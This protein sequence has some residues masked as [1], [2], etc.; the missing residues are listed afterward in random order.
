MCLIIEFPQTQH[1]RIKKVKEISEK[2]RK[3]ITVD[4]PQTIQRAPTAQVTPIKLSLH[5]NG[6]PDL[7]KTL[8]TSNDTNKYLTDC[9]YDLTRS[10]YSLKKAIIIVG[11]MLTTILSIVLVILVLR[12]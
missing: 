1:A 3:Q 10:I 5:V 11:S 8:E 6:I 7:V 9:F 12:G 2:K 4:R